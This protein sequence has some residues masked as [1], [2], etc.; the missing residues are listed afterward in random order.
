[1]AQRDYAELINL[2]AEMARGKG[3]PSPYID[4]YGLPKSTPVGAKCT[5]MEVANI[6]QDQ[7]RDWA[8]RLRAIADRLGPQ[9]GPQS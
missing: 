5:M 1:M 8:I 2:A 7:S 9:H 4:D 6:A 3:M